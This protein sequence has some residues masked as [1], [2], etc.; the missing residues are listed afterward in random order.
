MIVFQTEVGW[1]NAELNISRTKFLEGA[2]EKNPNAAL[3]S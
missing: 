1:E 2:W 3:L